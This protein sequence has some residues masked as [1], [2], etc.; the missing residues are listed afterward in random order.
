MWTEALKCSSKRH[1]KYSA[2]SYYYEVIYLSVWQQEKYSII[3]YNK[4]QRTSRVL[5]GRRTVS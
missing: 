2:T 1:Q 5:L 3:N 4:L